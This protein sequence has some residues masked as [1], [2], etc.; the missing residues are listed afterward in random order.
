MIDLLYLGP[1]AI[2][3]LFLL[4]IKDSW[5]YKPPSSLLD[6]LVAWWDLD[7]DVVAEWNRVLTKTERLFL[8]NFGDGRSYEEIS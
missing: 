4:G 2:F 6:G 8:Y 7:G 5:Y 1:I 3:I